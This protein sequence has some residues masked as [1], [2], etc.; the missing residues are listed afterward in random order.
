MGHRRDWQSLSAAED[1]EA[2]KAPSSS[3]SA[4]VAAAA[5]ESSTVAVAAAADNT[6]AVA[7]VPSGPSARLVEARCCSTWRRDLR[8]RKDWR[9]CR[10]R[11]KPQQFVASLMNLRRGFRAKAC[12]THQP[13]QQKCN[14][15]EL[16]CAISTFTILLNA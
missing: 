11:S 9:P 7:A 15:G 5:A 16:E 14:G 8:S 12:R 6:A 4:A 10:R 1:M 2:G 13:A 3:S